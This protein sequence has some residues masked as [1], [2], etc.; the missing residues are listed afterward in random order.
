MEGEPAVVVARHPTAATA[1]SDIALPAAPGFTA[2]LA[3]NLHL[4]RDQES[5]GGGSA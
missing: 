4:P 2:L 5:C 3:Q 1:I